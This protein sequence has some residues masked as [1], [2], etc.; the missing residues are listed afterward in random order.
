L[1]WIAGSIAL[2]AVAVVIAAAMMRHHQTC[3]WVGG[4]G[5]YDPPQHKVCH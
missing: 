3:T 5:L 2:V 1:K 4:V